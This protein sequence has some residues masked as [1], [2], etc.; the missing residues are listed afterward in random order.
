MFVEL[1]VLK[2]KGIFGNSYMVNLSLMGNN[3]NYLLILNFK[4]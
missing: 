2:E 1:I 4:R 3:E